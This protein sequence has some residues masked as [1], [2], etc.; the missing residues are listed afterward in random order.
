MITKKDRVLET[1]ALLFA[2]FGFE[3]TSMTMICNEAKVSKGLVY[4]HFSSKESILVEIFTAS[5]NKMIKVDRCN[6]PKDDP[7]KE[8]THLIHGVFSKLKNDR[9]FFQLNLNIMF[10]PS[11]R[12]L[13]AEH[14]K[15]RADLLFKTIKKLFDSI[16]P[17]RSEI[18]T[19]TLIAEIDGIALNYLSVF[20]NYPLNEM[21]N[22]LINKYCKP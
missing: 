20:D 9:L 19:Y 13:L 5:T 2:K 11:T 14:I 17:N 6:D 16:S 15:K 8:L 12:D 18:M 10:Q 21:K 22:E 4:H 1:A 7:Q 3:K